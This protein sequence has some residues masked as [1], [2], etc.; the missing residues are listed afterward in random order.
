MATI[1]STVSLVD[2]I[3]A[4]LNTIK[5]NVDDVVKS[6]ENMQNGMKT[7]Q[8]KANNFDWT[9]F[10]KNCE[11][12]GKK[13]S[14]LGTKMTLAFTTPL[15]LLGKKMYGN[16]TDYETA[17]VGMTK[18]VEGTEEQY[19]ALYEMALNFSE[20]DPT[21]FVDLM[22]TMQTAG[23]LGVG[24]DQMDNFTRSYTALTA[25]TDKHIDGEAGAADVASFLNI[26]DKG[27]QWI[28][29]FGSAIV[30]LGNNFNA[31][32]DQILAMANR[33]AAAGD[34]AGFSTP[35][36]LGM[37]T[38]FT[39]VGINAEA[40][41]SSA[42]KLIKQMQLAAEVGKKGQDLFG[43]EYGNATAFSRYI[44]SSE[45]L[46]DIAAN[47]NMTKEQVQSLGD[48]WLSLEQ[49]SAVS[50]KTADQFIKDWG[51]NPGQGMIDFFTGLAAVGDS[52]TESILS[53]LDTMGITEIRES[54]LVAAMASNPALFASAIE[55][56]V[57]AYSE[58]TAMWEEYEKQISTQEAQNQ[59]LANKAQNTMADFGDNL[60]TA[61]QPA[62]DCVNGLLDAFN[63]LSEVDQTN[64]INLLGALAITGP[65][66]VGVG[67]TVEAVG[68][69]SKGIKA[70]HDAGGVI[71]I[72]EKVGAFI[73]GTPVGTALAVAGGIAAIAAAISAIPTQTELV[74]EALQ[75]IPISIDQE[76][77]DEVM[78]QIDALQGKINEL[79]NDP[80]E[81]ENLERT[82]TSVEMGYG[83]NSMYANA[84]VYQAAEFEEQYETVANDYSA[85]IAEATQKI[86]DAEDEATKGYWLK[87]V[88][89]LEA[90]S[91]A[92][93]GAVKKAYT[94]NISSLYNGMVSQIPGFAQQME[95][96]ASQ[97]DFMGVLM[98]IG[99]FDW[100]AFA[101]QDQAE[102][103]WDA[104][105]KNM[106]SRA[107]DLGY[108]ENAG[109]ETKEHLMNAYETGF[110]NN[111][112]WIDML[113]DSVLADMLTSVQSIS[114]NPLA[115]TWLQSILDNP[116]LM[117]NLD[118]TNLT[119]AMDGIFKALDFKSAM[120]QAGEA[121]DPNSFGD[122]L[123]Q[124]LADGITGSQG[125]ATEASAAA[126]TA[127]VEALGTSLG[128]QSPSWIAMEQG[129]N[130]D[131]GL[132]QGIM[133]YV[134]VVT[135]AVTSTGAA[136]ISAMQ[137]VCNQVVATGNSIVNYGA[138]YSMGHNIGSGMAAGIR[139]SIPAAVAAARALASAVSS[140][141]RTR[142]KIHSP[143]RLFEQYGLYTGEGYVNGVYKMIGDAQD[144]IGALTGVKYGAWSNAWSNI[145]AFGALEIQDLQNARDE[146]YEAKVS[147]AD[148]KKI[149][150]LA[151]R[152][153]INQFT[154]AELH[155]EFTANNKIESD[156]DLD[157]VVSYLED[158]VAERLEM[159][160]EG[161]YE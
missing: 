90:E 113:Y 102:A 140:A 108:M 6:F 137:A 161:V 46:L 93:T 15:M 30:H 106:Y 1:S 76:Q 22:G 152:E 135:A 42:S 157:G 19:A 51:D 119:G 47:L 159:V 49:F 98:D 55:S 67:K 103:A 117:E 75:D 69:I 44:S 56:A 64:I 133:A 128:V 11:A 8:E 53:M 82:S 121:G 145:N 21:G 150:E 34:L 38:A 154:T 95:R 31:T 12:A 39:A 101:D 59:M 18:T 116:V 120:E 81:R 160:A 80:A 36:I 112:A 143:S 129:M 118:L 16:A 52:G 20:V 148:M 89:T 131:L 139:A 54:N 40:G 79:R 105:M 125:T 88:E 91:A 60:V 96:A 114:D 136:T 27:V 134:G 84:L 43:A 87:Q 57:A 122:Y 2:N 66:L 24:I 50:G 85:R 100:D 48:A 5:G 78:G 25:A 23:N 72:L 62:L 104:R 3:S 7:S 86:I 123:M 71:G 14:D 74:Y 41:G 142:L 158:Q 63:S 92:A 83:T 70:I 10:N 33:M 138:G 124:G 110:M 4:K 28:E 132:A 68:S 17:F 61:L 94:E 9:T 29:P 13:I 130:L 77:Y 109:Y 58:N 149:R 26:M 65:V 147:D 35:Q 97:Y 155:I 111:A 73:T 127:T 37:A 144:A 99:N 115:N 151:E 156:L 107:F 153:V 126:G 146:D 32:E 45:N 141:A